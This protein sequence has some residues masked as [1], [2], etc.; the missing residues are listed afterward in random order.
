MFRNQIYVQCTTCVVYVTLYL[1]FN[2]YT[3][4]SL[5][6]FLQKVKGFFIN[7]IPKIQIY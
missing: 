7:N 2:F 5:T 6:Y 4:D 1:L 3:F